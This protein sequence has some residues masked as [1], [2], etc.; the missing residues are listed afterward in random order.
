MFAIVCVMW[1]YALRDV[2]FAPIRFACACWREN[3]TS[4]SL[5]RGNTQCACVR[6]WLEVCVLCICSGIVAFPVGHVNPARSRRT[7]RSDRDRV[8]VN[9]CARKHSRAAHG[10]PQRASVLY[11]NVFRDLGLKCALSTALPLDKG[12]S[13]WG[14]VMFC[15]I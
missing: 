4:F 7:L 12:Q 5:S 1:F 9:V 15:V 6:R 3:R 13:R 14:Y 10:T 2:T 11:A 8:W